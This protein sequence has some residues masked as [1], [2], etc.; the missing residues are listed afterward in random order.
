MKQGLRGAALAA[1][2]GCAWVMGGVE[3]A[4][5]TAVTIGVA[6]SANVD[7]FG[8][9]PYVYGNEYQQIYS[10][11]GFAGPLSINYIS[12]FDFAT[13]GVGIGL[14][15]G[16]FTLTLS[17]TTA[18]VNALN[19]ILSDNI[20][21][22]AKVV[23]EGALPAFTRHDLIF[24]L[25]ADFAYDPSLGNLLLDVSTSD[26]KQTGELGLD[27]GTTAGLTSRASGNPAF[28]GLTTPNYGLVTEFS[29][30]PITPVPVPWSLPLFGLALVLLGTRSL[31][32]HSSNQ[33]A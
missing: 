1:V 29:D 5:A 28:P 19:P 12:F 2:M 9:E 17:T 32:R 21:S 22:D 26:A 30:E 15:T 20:G 14:D 13:G 4:E 18:A 16:N 27:A 24:S 7:P 33:A 23:Y 6:D 3:M 31:R 11:S 8:V 25:V 10:A